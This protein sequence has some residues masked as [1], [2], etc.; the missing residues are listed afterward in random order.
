MLKL[1]DFS[2]NTKL[3]WFRV[4]IIFITRFLGYCLQDRILWLNGSLLLLFP[5]STL[6]VVLIDLENLTGILV[7]EVML[8]W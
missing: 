3:L 4:A 7:L 8:W 5:E 1:T 2:A 6:G